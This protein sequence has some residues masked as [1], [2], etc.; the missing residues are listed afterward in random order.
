MNIL[1]TIGNVFA[2]IFSIIFHPLFY[3]TLGSIY[4]IHSIPEYQLFQASFLLQIIWLLFLT[5]YILPLIIAGMYIG[6]IHIFKLNT[7]PKQQRLFLLIITTIIYSYAT[8]S[9]TYLEILTAIKLNIIIC[10]ITMALSLA[11]TFFWKISLHMIGIGG[12]IGLQIALAAHG[13]TL[14]AP[15]IGFSFLLAGIIAASRLYLNAHT[16][17]QIYIGFIGSLIFNFT[18]LYIL[19]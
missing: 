9:I 12:F 7:P 11:V 8:L 3:S 16:P 15:F 17:Y 1:T 14:Y 5:L 4:I 18:S 10:A 6:S 13:Y 19:L 2:W